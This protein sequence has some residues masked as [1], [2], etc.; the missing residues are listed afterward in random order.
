MVALNA[1]PRGR[2]TPA[3][4]IAMM[5]ARIEVHARTSMA[6]AESMR[7][8]ANVKTVKVPETMEY[9]IQH[10]LDQ[11]RKERDIISP[12]MPDRCHETHETRSSDASTFDEVC[13]NC[14]ATDSAGGGWAGL[15]WPCLTM[16]KAFM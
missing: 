5:L 2:S 12:D 8:N 3:M 15:R 10:I 7:D 4:D 11:I 16:V 1:K 14:G 13:K 6:Y 9:S